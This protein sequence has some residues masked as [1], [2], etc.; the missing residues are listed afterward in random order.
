M[1]GVSVANVREDMV[2]KGVVGWERYACWALSALA[3][4]TSLTPMPPTVHS[5]HS[6]PPL[7]WF[8]RSLATPVRF[9]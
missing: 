5:V 8:Y 3:Q 6:L 9:P 4:P 2:G 7:G 1:D